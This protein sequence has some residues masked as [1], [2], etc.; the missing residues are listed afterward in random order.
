M[1]VGETVRQ[2]AYAEAYRA[3]SRKDMVACKAMGAF[4]RTVRSMRIQSFDQAS[5]IAQDWSDC[6][7]WATKRRQRK[8]LARPAEVRENE[9]AANALAWLAEVIAFRS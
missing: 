6:A 1:S 4:A 8:G 5:R 2:I 3:L 9:T 7:R